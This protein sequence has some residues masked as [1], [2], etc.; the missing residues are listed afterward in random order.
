V[1]NFLVNGVAAIRFLTILP[2][3]GK[4]GH[5]ED[6]LA[7]SLVFFPLVGLA[8]GIV[9]SGTA[10][11]LW[12]FLPPLLAAIFLTI[13][14]AG[15]SGG[16]HL[17]GLA[18][19]GDGFCSSRPR[20]Q[21]LEIMR[22]SRIGAM[23]VFW[24]VM[25]FVVKIGGLVGL[26]LREAMTAALLMPLAG[27]CAIVMMMSILPYARK[28]GGLGKLFY[29]GNLRFAAVG[30]LFLFSLISLLA[31]GSAGILIVFSVLLMLFF[32]SLICKRVIGGTT[33]DALGANCELSEAMVVV[34][35]AGII[36][37]S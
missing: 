4:L 3:P 21:I 2:I 31:A 32:F 9:A 11:V 25:I 22:D 30:G 8:L 34:A 35:M 7:G 33:G 18:D 13:L 5:G 29:T 6:G 16:L 37:N 1:K 27:R 12:T 15:F 14:L 20:E 23:G 36:W 19:T 10:F 28:E 24:L 17:D 26:Q